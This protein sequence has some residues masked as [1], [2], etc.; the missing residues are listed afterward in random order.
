M[1]SQ[2]GSFISLGSFLACT[3]IILKVRCSSNTV[4]AMSAHPL[5]W[6]SVPCTPVCCC[7]LDI[8]VIVSS[9][10]IHLSICPSVHPPIHP[11]ISKYF[12]CARSCARVPQCHS[13][14]FF[15]S[16]RVAPIAYGGS[17]ARG[18]IGTVAASLC[19]SHSNTRSEPHLWPTSQLTAMPDPKSTE[20]GQGSNL[21]PHGHVRFIS[22][23]PWRELPP[24]SSFMSIIWHFIASDLL[25]VGKLDFWSH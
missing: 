21:P 23:E 12:L 6:A 18:G 8:Y 4:M 3:K 5:P 7:L 13:F 17:Q 1:G 16:L 20:W 19:H 24:V 15:W 22:T 11:S 25:P 10:F 2:D 14:L 9:S